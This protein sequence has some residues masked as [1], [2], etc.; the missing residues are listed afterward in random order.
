VLSQAD[1][2]LRTLMTKPGL[3]AGAWYPV[4]AY[5][6]LH[7]AAASAFPSEAQL[8]ERIGHAAMRSDLS[9]IYRVFTYFLSPHSL[10]ARAAPMFATYWE[11]VDVDI[12]R[13]D[14]Q[15]VKVGIGGA[16]GFDDALWSDIM[17]GITAC[18]EESGAADIVVEIAERDM[19]RGHALLD[20]R[21]HV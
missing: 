11:D 7:A 18:L 12:E 13:I 9:G 3:K 15:H 6:A 4:A 8:P 14:H 16:V 21:W 10:V 2:G 17:G 1:D 19:S 5:R 20:V